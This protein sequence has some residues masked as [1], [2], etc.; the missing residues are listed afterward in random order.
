M[1]R[2]GASTDIT[3]RRW[4]IYFIY[5]FSLAFTSAGISAAGTVGT[6]YASPE[7][8]REAK[9]LRHISQL[10]RKLE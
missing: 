4:A 1:S 2:P 9:L 3:S 10:E 7:N 5:W 8:E 6:A